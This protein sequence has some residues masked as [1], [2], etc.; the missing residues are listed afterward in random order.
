VY[1]A[2]DVRAYVAAPRLKGGGYV[3]SFGVHQSEPRVGTGRGGA[4]RGP[5]RGFGY[6]FARFRGVLQVGKAR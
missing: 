1:P 2:V 4:R 6:D 5:G 3:A